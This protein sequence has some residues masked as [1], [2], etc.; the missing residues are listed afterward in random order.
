VSVRTQG[1]DY[2]LIHECVEAR[3]AGGGSFEIT[4]GVGRNLLVLGCEPELAE[5]LASYLRTAAAAA[6]TGAIPAISET[7]PELAGR[8]DRI[9]PTVAEVTAG[10]RTLSR[11]LHSFRRDLAAATP[12]AMVTPFLIIACVLMYASMVLRGVDAFLPTVDQLLSWGANSG[13]R[14]VLRHEY[15]RLPASVFIHGGLIHLAV[16]MWCLYS[17]GP[18]V[19][20]LFGNAVFAVIYMSAGIGGAIAS[21]AAR[22]LRPSVGASGA[23]FGIFGAL[24][25]FLIV[26]RKA[27]PGSVLKP[28]RSS[29]LSFVIFNTLFAAAVPL[30]DQEAHMGGLA[31]GFLAGLLLTRPWPVVQSVGLHLR[32]FALALALCGALTGIAVSVSKWRERTLPPVAR[33]EDFEDQA[34]F[35]LKEFNAMF[36]AMPAPNQLQDAAEDSSRRKDLS[37]KLRGLRVRASA[38]LKRLKNVSPLDADTRALSQSI[39]EGQTRVLDTI[40]AGLRYLDTRDREWLIGANGARAGFSATNQA[41]ANYNERRSRYLKDIG[42]GSHPAP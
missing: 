31:T 23:I 5:A 20:R 4:L 8:I 34:S 18:L 2:E 7:D 11:D 14:V 21:M 24:L 38:N 15:W 3:S 6:R 27:V 33:L 36:E 12:R 13:A 41:I 17:I 10:I 40:D 26:H 35:S 1:I 30:I 37:D 28:L 9:L 19:E 25:A 29:A 16:N 32:R 42:L 22:P 39:I